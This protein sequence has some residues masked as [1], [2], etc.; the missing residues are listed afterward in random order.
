[1]ISSC[2]GDLLF[3]NEL[4]SVVISEG[5]AGCKKLRIILYYKYKYLDTSVLS[6]LEILLFPIWQKWLLYDSEIDL[7]SHSFI[8]GF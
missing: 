2:P 7:G 1:V 4:I 5:T 3:D 6:I 8:V